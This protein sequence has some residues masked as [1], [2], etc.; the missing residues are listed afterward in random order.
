MSKNQIEQ[1]NATRNQ[2]MAKY[3]HD[4]VFLGNN[5]FDEKTLNNTTAAAEVTITSGTLLF[6]L[7]PTEVDVLD[8]AANIA[9]VVGIAAM[10][11]DVAVA[12][13][14]T[15]DI[16]VCLR[17]EVAEELIDLPAGVTLDT[18]IP[19]TQLTLRDRLNELGFHLVAGT[20]NTKF[21]N[22]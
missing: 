19:T 11:A 18:V 9:N 16:N 10:E 17:G 4:H 7:S 3:T 6:K 21:D 12:N 1:V 8:A 22:E 14:A 13:A 20:N 15:L 5:D 2:S